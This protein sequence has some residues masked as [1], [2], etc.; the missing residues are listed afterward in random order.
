M[1]LKE[2]SALLVLSHMIG[3]EETDFQGIEIDSRRVKQGDLFICLSGQRYDGHDFAA[4]AVEQGA[5]ALVVERRLPLAVP[6]LVVADSRHALAVIANHYYDYPSHELQLIGVTGTN[7]KTTTTFVLEQVLRDHG[8]ETGLMGTIQMKIGSHTY[9]VLN[10]TQGALELQ[11][12]LRQMKDAGA[13]Y[14][15]MEVSSHALPMGRV[16][17]CRFRTV[18]FTNLSQDHLDYHKTMEQY[19]AAKGLLFSRMG[20]VFYAARQHHQYAVLNADDDMAQRYAELTAAQVV[21]YGIEREAHVR[22]ERIALNARGTSFHVKTFRGALDLQLQLVG[23]F[24]VYNVLAALTAALLEGVPL[25]HI[26]Q[27]VERLQG[28]AGRFEVID[29]GQSFATIVDYAHTPDSLKNV[30]QTIREFAT[31]SVI[32]VFGCGG[33]RD[34]T[35]RP[36]MGQIAAQLCDRLIITSDNARSE[37]PWSILLD[38]EHG[39]K[40]AGMPK[41]KYDLIVDRQK[42]IEF[43]IEKAQ[44]NDVILIAGKGHE[45]YQEIQG[46]KYDFDDRVVAKNAIRSLLRD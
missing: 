17:G 31:G 36:Q 18:I 25:V 38:I 5:V 37:D 22:A 15:I 33:D 42:A 21:T 8:Y 45:T 14:C 26:K 13:Q 32:C 11:R 43:A 9:E 3:D 7:G 2:L 44:P 28:I 35:K 30:L 23:K 24:S 41:E 34:R 1:K 12:H 6:M 19:A 46:V 39:I 16:K 27:S 20:N 29:A 10:T 4:M 40:L